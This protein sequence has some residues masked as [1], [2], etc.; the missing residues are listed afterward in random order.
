[1]NMCSGW[2]ESLADVV[3][4]FSRKGFVMPIRKQAGKLLSWVAAKKSDCIVRYGF[5]APA[6]GM[7]CI[8]SER[9]DTASLQSCGLLA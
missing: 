3:I 5:R 2:P 8:R 9:Q 7:G 1:L 6:N 4:R